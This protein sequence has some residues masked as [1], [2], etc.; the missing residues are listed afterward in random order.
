[1]FQRLFFVFEHLGL[2]GFLAALL[3]FL[4]GLWYA[5]IVWFRSA[6][7]LWI[8][9]S[10]LQSD[11]Q[12]QNDDR[13]RIQDRV[14]SACQEAK[15]KLDLKAEEN[16]RLQADI[17]DQI[18]LLQ[19]SDS[20]AN[21]LSAQ[22]SA[23]QSSLEAK[24]KAHA[25]VESDMKTLREKLATEKGA[26]NKELTKIK[27]KEISARKQNRNLE[28]Q[29]EDIKKE[30]SELKT[31]EAENTTRLQTLTAIESEFNSLQ[32][33]HRETLNE[34]IKLASELKS[35][36]TER[37]DY[38]TKIT[39]NETAWKRQIANNERTLET[40][41]EEL[42][43]SNSKLGLLSENLETLKSEKEKITAESAETQQS[44]QQAKEDLLR[45]TKQIEN[46]N[47]QKSE[48]E[49]ALQQ[50]RAQHADL[51]KQKELEA[52]QLMEKISGFESDL[53]K[54]ETDIEHGIEQLKLFETKFVAAE[55]DRE[56]AKVELDSERANTSKL[57]SDLE[58]A[59][60]ELGEKRE[61]LN[62]LVALK[63]QIESDLNE[64]KSSLQELQKEHS[65][66]QN[67][68]QQ[69]TEK[70]DALSNDHRALK[71]DLDETKSNFA[72]FQQTAQNTNSDLESAQKDL[73]AK[74]DELAQLT[75]A[76]SKLESELK[77]AK[78]SLDELNQT[79][80]VTQ[81]DLENAKLD[82]KSNAEKSDSTIA[83]LAELQ[84]SHKELQSQ[85]DEASQELKRLEA[86]Q[87]NAKSSQETIIN[88][89]A[90]LEANREK[91][92]DAEKLI[93]EKES[94]LADAKAALANA[95]DDSPRVAELKSRLEKASN[96]LAEAR[97]NLSQLQSELKL[98]QEQAEEAVQLQSEL[99]AKSMQLDLL[100]HEKST[101]ADQLK[102]AH[103][104]LAVASTQQ[105]SPEQPA[106]KQQ[107]TTSNELSSTGKKIAPIET[108]ESI[109]TANATDTGNAT[110]TGSAVESSDARPT[111][112]TIASQEP[113]NATA[114]SE[115]ASTPKKKTKSKSNPDEEDFS[116]PL[117]PHESSYAESLAKFEGEDV[118]VERQKGV[119]F[120]NKPNAI[121]ELTLIR[122][123][124][125][126][127]E[128]QLHEDG[129][130]Q[131]KQIAEWNE[132]NAWAF[133]EKLQ[134]KGRIEREEWIP[135]AQMLM[136]GSEVS[137]EVL[138]K[139]EG[140]TIDS[141]PQ[142]GV[143]YKS[144]PANADDLTE[145][146]GISPKIERQLNELGIYRFEQLANLNSLNRN[147]L[148]ER[149]GLAGNI[150]REDWTAQATEFIE[151][152]KA[153][154]AQTVVPEPSQP[155]PT[156]YKKLT[157]K[158]DKD[159]IEIHEQRGIVYKSAP[160]GIDDLTR[161]K[162]IG[163]VNEQK[164]NGTGV[165][166]FQQIADWNEYN[167]WAFEQHLAFK[168]RIHREDW[169]GQ[170]KQL[171]PFSEFGAEDKGFFT[172]I[173]VDL[174]QVDQVV[175]VVDVSRSLSDS[176]FRVSK[177]E[178]KKAIRQLPPGCRY[179]V[180]FFSGATWF[181]SERMIEG[182]ARGEKVIIQSSDGMK[183]WKAG[184]PFQFSEGNDRLPVGEWLAADE[185][186]VMQTLRDVDSVERSFGTTWHLPLTMAMNLDPT[187]QAIFFM[188]DGETANQDQIAD[189]MIALSKE[190]GNPAIYTTALM[191]PATSAPLAKIAKSTGANFSL[192]I[193]GGEVLMGEPLTRYLEEKG[194]SLD[195]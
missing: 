39:S 112:E 130:F 189:D 6:T 29:I 179:Q 78:D 47:S 67:Q 161:I 125:P 113:T 94:A 121:D 157:K 105:K 34:K 19:K 164:L 27:D 173:G 171:A 49:S 190:R 13:L 87:E 59:R 88:L 131:F 136:Q 151:S 100:A 80:A 143:V 28:R 54:K 2:V 56:S 35:L 149:L 30:H 128:S 26:L 22:L 116:E 17:D 64:T 104:D 11:L 36:L 142:Y 185:E 68:H 97:T 148:N 193:K 177:I 15:R 154:D 77:S 5:Y 183:H 98:A 38:K 81:K 12:K 169:V 101:I 115:K 21:Q 174:S 58:T 53:R 73:K 172:K 70:H 31:K 69:L 192:V 10:K 23:T 187:P 61:E 158:Y 25:K 119:L 124:G 146:A 33:T 152:Q 1:M 168:G 122:G 57:S 134:F 96:D 51:E 163:K 3:F 178:L 24:E 184:S 41:R 129:V 140:E 95:T 170:A 109:A 93:A 165:Y 52:S 155:K 144:A 133:N 182:G 103:A 137:A 110:E 150:E 156:T 118:R 162:G 82:A 75:V 176:Q 194:I 132:Y 40:T 180:I 7:R 159:Q 46:L 90:Q 20:K 79:H 89:K 139:F 186:T 102:Q 123:V 62:K 126:K 167:V 181:A 72:E 117:L 99:K 92:S 4:I 65:D 8:Q 76:K 83:E 166:R 107:S 16:S 74:T 66:L 50:A 108:P 9:R 127:I 37:D 111:N 85:L 191:A 86:A 147:A 175:F 42:K 45:L 48:M 71:T 55:S 145:I 160:N 18:A 141:H 44:L 106:E 135:Q 195:D 63:S 43:E 14:L 120:N 153:D 84:S 91:L 188:T 32:S 60:N 114:E 138:A